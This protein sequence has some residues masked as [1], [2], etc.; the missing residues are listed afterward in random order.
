V[1]INRQKT[2]NVDALTGEATQTLLAT[3]RTEDDDA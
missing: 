2:P 1:E 3:L